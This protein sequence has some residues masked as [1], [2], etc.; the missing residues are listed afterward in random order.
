MEMLHHSTYMF[1]DFDQHA[2]PQAPWLRTQAQL[3]N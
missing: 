2:T 3:L 1:L